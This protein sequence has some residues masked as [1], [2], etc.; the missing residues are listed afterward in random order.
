MYYTGFFSSKW[1]SE[2]FQPFAFSVPG[3]SHDAW[4]WN[5]IV[6]LWCRILLGKKERL[7]QRIRTETC[8]SKFFIPSYRY[9]RWRS[10]NVAIK[11]C[12]CSQSWNW[13]DRLYQMY[14]SDENAEIQ[15]WTF[16]HTLSRRYRKQNAIQ[17]WRV[18][19]T[20]V[21]PCPNAVAAGRIASS[22]LPG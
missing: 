20:E 4:T 17:T 19:I 2:P 21:I 13:H 6:N 11:F 5:Q 8:T 15:D 1:I 3:C 7:T 9:F 12:L 16:R 10:Y 22:G 18:S 14:L